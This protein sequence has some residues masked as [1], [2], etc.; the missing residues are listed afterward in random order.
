MQLEKPQPER[1]FRAPKETESCS[2]A[3]SAGGAA[4]H[5][6]VRMG[7]ANWMNGQHLEGDHGASLVVKGGGLVAEVGPE[8]VA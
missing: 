1:G 6:E 8:A 7:Q 4:L 2:I 5:Q 3:E